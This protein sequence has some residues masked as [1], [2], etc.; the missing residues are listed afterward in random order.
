MLKQVYTNINKV[1]HRPLGNCMGVTDMKIYTFAGQQDRFV[2]LQSG[3]IL[4]I[5]STDRG[6]QLSDTGQGVPDQPWMVP[7][8]RRVRLCP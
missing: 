1:E 4:A 8:E 5:W 6:A 2:K 7:T 3:T